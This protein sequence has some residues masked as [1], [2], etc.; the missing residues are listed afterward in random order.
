MAT[1]TTQQTKIPPPSAAILQHRITLGHTFK[2]GGQR[3]SLTKCVQRLGDYQSKDDKP[4]M[5]RALI[6]E[7]KL[8]QLEST[9]QFMQYKQQLNL[10]PE[11]HEKQAKSTTENTTMEELEKEVE[12]AK[13]QAEISQQRQ[14]CS[15]EYDAVAKLALDQTKTRGVLE[16]EV[17]SMHEDLHRME[18]ETKRLDTVLAKRE[19]Q[20]HLLMKLMTDMKKSVEEENAEEA[21]ERE[22]QEEQESER[23]KQK[24]QEDHGDDHDAAAT[25][26]TTTSATQ[27]PDKRIATQHADH[28]AASSCNPRNARQG[29]ATQTPIH[30]IKFSSSPVV[31]AKDVLRRTHNTRD[32]ADTR[33]CMKQAMSEYGTELLRRQL[34]DLAKNPIDLVSVGLADDSNL[35]EWEILVMG[36]DGTHY[37]GGFFKARL[38][39][40]P[41]FPNMPP[42][43]TF[44]SEMWHPNVYQDG[45]VCISIL[46]PPGE[47][48]FNSQESADE[49][50][51]PILGVEQILISVISMLSD[52][53]DESPANLD[54]AVMWRND[55]PAFKKKVRQVVRK[56]Q[57]EC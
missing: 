27:V 25:A 30:F 20:F 48:E 23:K 49:R 24:L 7:I 38:V 53:N 47:D 31:P 11:T 3:G 10:S 41:D 12:A 6:N 43:M 29:K 2:S 42:T 40:P 22:S 21:N 1:S 18:A 46:H 16:N 54:A 32:A 36:P 57:E 39:F 52:P 33:T 37:E 19:R 5:K 45:R 17:K 44:V 50:W 14:S 15:I 9:K 4:F 28:P 35:Y 26:T 13:G 56:S 55:R 34:N 8:Y 51:R